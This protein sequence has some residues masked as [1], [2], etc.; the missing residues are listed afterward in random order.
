RVYEPSGAGPLHLDLD[1]AEL[2]ANRR[3]ERRQQ[4]VTR[5]KLPRRL[6]ATRDR[7]VLAVDVGGSAATDG[8]PDLERAGRDAALVV[9]NEHGRAA[10]HRSRAGLRV[11]RGDH[12]CRLTRSP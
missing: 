12:L 2:S 9:T 5:R 4:A 10:A 6:Q 8:F 7:K 1:A 3:I 11:K